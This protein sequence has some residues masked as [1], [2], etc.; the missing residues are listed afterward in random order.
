M[1]GGGVNAKVAWESPPKLRKQAFDTVRSLWVL[2]GKVCPLP[3]VVRVC[4]RRG[5]AEE[6]HYQ[7]VVCVLLWAPDRHVLEQTTI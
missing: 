4:G 1:P 6:T 7:L 5:S 3:K 2:D